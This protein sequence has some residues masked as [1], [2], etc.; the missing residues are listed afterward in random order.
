LQFG[1]FRFANATD[2]ERLASYTVDQLADL[3]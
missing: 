1:Q 2:V 3:R